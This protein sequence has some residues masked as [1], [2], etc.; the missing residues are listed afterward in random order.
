MG[1]FAT[2][3]TVASTRV[4]ENTWGMTANAV[5]SLSLDP[6]L[7]LLAVSRDSQSYAK[8]KA[9]ACFAL[10]ILSSQQEEISNRFACSGPKDF[11][12]LEVTSAKTG[13]PIL[14]HCLGWVDCHL[15]ETLTGGDH[16][17]F[18]GEIVAGE[19]GGGSPLVFYEGKYHQLSV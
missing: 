14:L 2:G 8:F 15:K 10:N 13:A 12:G 11:T 5:M 19:I 18:V 1:K 16:D 7:A 9:G 4:G 17:M 6:P 3:V